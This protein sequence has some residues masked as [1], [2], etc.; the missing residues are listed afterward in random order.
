MAEINN[1]IH[2]TSPIVSQ[3][4]Q[5]K[6]GNVALLAKKN[7]LVMDFRLPGIS[8]QMG[9]RHVEKGFSSIFGIFDDFSKLANPG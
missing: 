6:C 8:R 2:E 5:K 4:L 7:R 3:S 9:L 1:A